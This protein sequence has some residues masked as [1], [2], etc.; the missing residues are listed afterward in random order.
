MAFRH[1]AERTED[2]AGR[3]RFERLAEA[4]SNFTASPLFYCVCLLLVAGFLVAHALG[5]PL[6]WQLFAADLMTAVTLLLLALLKNAER[7]AE[8]AVQRK[9]D[10]IAAALL[11]QGGSS[12]EARDALR[13]VIGLHEDA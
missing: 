5:L 12:H 4:A 6:K 7:R 8:H 9:L 10:A 1:P 11:E 2:E 3:G 13:A